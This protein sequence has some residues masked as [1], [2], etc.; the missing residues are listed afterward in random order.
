MTHKHIF[1]PLKVGV[2]DCSNRL[3]LAPM[4]TGFI[5]SAGQPSHRFTEFHKVYAASGLGLLCIG[6]VAVSQGAR[7]SARS[8]VLDSVEKAERLGGTISLIRKIGCIPVVQLMHAGRQANPAEIGGEIVAPS[9]I[10]CPVI[11]ARPKELSRKQIE[12][13]IETFV[14]AAEHARSAGVRLL[15]LHAAHGYLLAEFLSPY[16]NKRNDKYGGAFNNRFRILAQIIEAVRGLGGIDV[17]VRISGNE[18]VEG[19]LKCDDIPALINAIQDRGAVYVSVSA[20]VYNR[21]DH[22][23]PDRKLGHAIHA[24]LGRLAKSVARIPIFL[25]GNIGSL[26][27]A[28]KVLAEGC[29]DLVLLGRA[30]L[31]D[32]DLIHKTQNGHDREVQPCTMC[33][34]CKYHSRGL[35]HIACPHNEFL[36][37]VLRDTILGNDG[38]AD[39]AY[40]AK[41]RIRLR[42]GKN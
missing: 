34:I 12:E 1:Q 15:E 6:G 29:A 30:M 3:G 27:T 7:P 33:Q 21:D 16:S 13:I 11:G 8:L 38:D 5:D 23:M 9:P 40:V 24:P 42:S 19:G 25:S 32:P 37:D 41:M 10:P 28:E 31:A 14:S 2:E 20:G 36:W 4:N 39:T 17:G 22:I 18:F 35:P 26:G